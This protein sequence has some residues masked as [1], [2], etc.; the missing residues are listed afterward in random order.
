MRAADVY[1]AI[2][3]QRARLRVAGADD[4][5]AI[6]AALVRARL[7]NLDPVEC[8][9]EAADAALAALALRPRP[10]EHEPRRRRPWRPRRD[11]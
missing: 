6:T 2:E 11:R 10:W 4:R 1:V 3:N 5:T 7:H 8:C 9:R